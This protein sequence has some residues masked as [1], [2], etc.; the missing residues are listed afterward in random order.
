[1]VVFEWVRIISAGID[2][3]SGLPSPISKGIIVIVIS[4]TSPKERKL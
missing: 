4:S 1:M 2:P 3:K